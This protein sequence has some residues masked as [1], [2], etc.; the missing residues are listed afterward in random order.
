MHY[1][2]FG[3]L[4]IVGV[5]RVKNIVNLRTEIDVCVDYPY[6]IFSGGNLLLRRLRD[7]LWQI[8]EHIYRIILDETRNQK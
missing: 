6:Y 3:S 1:H 7:N 5:L 8:E 4:F 2:P